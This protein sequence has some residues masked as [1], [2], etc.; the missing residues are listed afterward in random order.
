MDKNTVAA[1]RIQR[2]KIASF[3]QT[4]NPLTGDIEERVLIDTNNRGDG[5]ILLQNHEVEQCIKI[6]FTKY[7]GARK[8]QTFLNRQ[9]I[10]Q[11][12]AI[13]QF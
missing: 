10:N 9:Q 7:K 2:R 13:S 8:I 6:Y 1:Y 11:Q 3:K 12:I 5:K 4:L